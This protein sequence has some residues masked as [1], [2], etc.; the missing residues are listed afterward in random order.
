MQEIIKI[1][2]IT[3]LCKSQNT[4]NHKIHEIITY[5]KSQ[6]A[7]NQKYSKYENT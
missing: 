3:K 7:I 4:G 2:E 6:H 5:I 1:K